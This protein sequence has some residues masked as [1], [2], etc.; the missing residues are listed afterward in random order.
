MTSS[1]NSTATEVT[2]TQDAEEV[3]VVDVTRVVLAFVE[4]A[5]LAAMPFLSIS[6]R[7]L[8]RTLQK[9]TA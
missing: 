5:L 6:N 9:L 8:D 2:E 1:L 4:L 3:L 7:Q